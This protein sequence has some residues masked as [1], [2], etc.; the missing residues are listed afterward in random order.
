MPEPRKYPI[1][2]IVFDPCKDF[3]K[4]K[5]ID[6]KPD[7]FDQ[8]QKWIIGKNTAKAYIRLCDDT[9]SSCHARIEYSPW[10]GW[11]IFDGTEERPSTNGTF[12]YL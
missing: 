3:P 7:Q 11:T 2:R 12:V 5:C 4:G 1:L 9:I 6:I 10:Y 8:S